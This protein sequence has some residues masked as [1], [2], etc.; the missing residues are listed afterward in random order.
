[1]NQPHVVQPQPVFQVDPFVVQALRAVLGK[2]LVV[3]TIKGSVSGDLRDVKPDHV[4]VQQA[5]GKPVYV[6]IFQIVWSMPV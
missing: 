5:D 3:E 4:V 6:R 1:M 2:K